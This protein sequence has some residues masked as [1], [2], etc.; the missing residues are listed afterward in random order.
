MTPPKSKA[1][2]A[3]ACASVATGIPAIEPF[4]SFPY[5][6]LGGD[7]KK[8]FGFEATRFAQ[9]C[10]RLIKFALLFVDFRP[11]RKAGDGPASQFDRPIEIDKRARSLFSFGR[12]TPAR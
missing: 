9:I 2:G 4:Q 12:P 11:N 3:L 5:F 8:A 7:V 10:G 1:R 6:S